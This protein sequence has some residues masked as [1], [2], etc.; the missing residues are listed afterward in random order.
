[1]A[2]AC[3]AGPLTGVR[4]V[5]V[6]DERHIRDLFTD[7]LRGAGADVRTAA[8]AREALA[9]V[10]AEMPQVLVSDIMMP[11]EDGYWLIAAIRA[12]G[13]R[14]P[15]TVAITGDARKHPRD[16]LLRAGY[17]AHLPKPI[18]LQTLTA[19]VARLAGRP[20]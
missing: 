5:V 7:S 13:P 20:V 12:L 15:R 1:M 2:H 8:S 4:V 14:R 6:D 19:T 17:D 10:E 3:A 18:P 16:E 11:H 9:M